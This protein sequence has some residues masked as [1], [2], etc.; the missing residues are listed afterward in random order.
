MSKIIPQHIAYAK[1]PCISWPKNATEVAV[2]SLCNDP[3]VNRRHYSCRHM[4]PMLSMNI[5]I[6]S[7]V[8][9]G[10]INRNLCIWTLILNTGNAARFCEIS[11]AILNDVI[12][13]KIKDIQ[14]EFEGN[15][16]NIFLTSS[17][18]R[19]SLS[20]RVY[21]VCAAKSSVYDYNMIIMHECE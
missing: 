13:S 19:A 18:T 12:R 16:C 20:V 4:W 7:G 14:R 5:Y 2:V 21:V 17:G 1:D 8:P 15:I 10:V 9:G 11:V 3:V 6:H